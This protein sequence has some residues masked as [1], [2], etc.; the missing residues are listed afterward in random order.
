MRIVA[1]E[2]RGRRLAA[3]EGRTTRPTSDRVREA[4]FDALTARLGPDLGAGRVLD[5]FAGTGALGLEA[6]SR[7]ACRAVF[8]ERDRPALRALASNIETLGATDRALVVAGDAE[9]PVLARALADGPFA[10]LLL[11]PPYRMDAAEVGEIVGRS[12]GGLAPD[13]V[14]AWEHASGT[15]PEAP[16]GWTDDRTYR[17]GDTAVTLFRRDEG[18]QDHP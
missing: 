16:P 2:W 8:V 11:D 15:R 7:G 3:P 5:L 9:G 18:G 14:I 12:L 1:G 13:A 6:L 10:L 4:L 17:H